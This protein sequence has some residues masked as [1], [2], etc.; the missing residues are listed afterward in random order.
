[1]EEEFWALWKDGIP[2]PESIIS[3]ISRVASRREVT[4]ED[5]KPQQVPA[6]A[7]VEA[8]IYRGGEQLQPWQRSFVTMFMGIGRSG[9]ARLLLADEVELKTLSMATSALI[10]VLWVMVRY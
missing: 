3:E 9:K 10:S 7:M 1:M 8:P 4:V 5:L 6:A 2:L